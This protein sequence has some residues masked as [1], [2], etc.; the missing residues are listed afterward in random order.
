MKLNIILPDISKPLST[1]R[2]CVFVVLVDAVSILIVTV[3]RDFD[4]VL[5]RQRI[6]R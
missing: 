3:V 4:G 1:V 6:G 2:A 5:C